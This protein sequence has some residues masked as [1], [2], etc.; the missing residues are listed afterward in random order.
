VW[1]WGEVKELRSQAAAAT[2]GLSPLEAAAGT[3]PG[4]ME[5]PRTKQTAAPLVLG[6]LRWG[7]GGIQVG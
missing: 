6:V 3:G 4:S 5:L 2:T 1:A 7:T